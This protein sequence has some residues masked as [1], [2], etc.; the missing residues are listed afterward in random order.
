MRHRDGT[1]FVE[2]LLVE[3]RDADGLSAAGVE[4][5]P[6][7]RLLRHVARLRIAELD[8]LCGN[9]AEDALAVVEVALDEREDVIDG[10]GRLIG[11]RLDLDRAFHGL[12]DEDLTCAG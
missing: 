6:P 7:P 10:L 12:D 9:D 2:T 4:A 5:A 8:E 1:H 3:L 11:I